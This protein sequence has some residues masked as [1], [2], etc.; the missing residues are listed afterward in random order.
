MEERQKVKGRRQKGR[1]NLRDA[2]TQRKWEEKM[3][4]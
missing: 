1:M 3:R 4:K 2:E